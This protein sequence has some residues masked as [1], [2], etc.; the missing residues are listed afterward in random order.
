MGIIEIQHGSGIYLRQTLEMDNND[1]GFWF[2]LHKSESYEFIAVRE[3]LECKAIDLIPP[4][5]YDSIAQQLHDCLRQIHVE[6]CDDRAYMS[7][8]MEFHDILRDAAHNRV[9]TK[10]CREISRIVYFERR[11]MSLDIE[12]RIKSYKEHVAIQ[13]AFAVGSR[14]LIK[15]AVVA[16]YSSVRDSFS[17][18]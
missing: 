15:E 12:R 18:Y 16:H 10:L 3:A 11:I 9:I 6:H 17:C 4:E 8:D 1:M 5:E 13:A 14:A 7:N 2:V